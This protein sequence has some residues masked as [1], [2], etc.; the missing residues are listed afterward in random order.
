MPAAGSPTSTQVPLL[1]A[2]AETEIIIGTATVPA[3]PTQSFATLTPSTQKNTSTPAPTATATPTPAATATQPAGSCTD[4]L[5]FVED[6]TVPDN[7]E[8][9]PGEDFTKTWRLQNTGTCTW[10]SAYSLVFASGDQMNGTSPSP[11]VGSTAPGSTLDVSVNLKAPGTVG[12]Y[13]GNW[14]LKNPSGTNFGS[15]ANATQPFY[16]L[17]NVVEGV[18]DLNLGAPTWTDNMDTADNWFLLSTANT[19]FTEGDGKLVMTASSPSGGDEW[20]LSNKPSLTDYYLQATFIT[21]SACSGLDRYGLLARAPDPSQGYVLEFSCDGHYRLY[22]WDGKNYSAIQE[23]K[24]V[25]S[26]HT[27]PNQTN[28]MGFWMKGTTLRIYANGYKLAEFTDS[29]FNHGQFGLVI[30]SANTN[31][32][33]TSVDQISYW[34]LTSQ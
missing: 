12:T 27:G 9:L 23:W 20:G 8:L 16:V 24:S 1:T 17:I 2:A 34:D 26:I 30:G 14:M 11:L 10:T 33:T 31:N 5:K 21:G 4:L 19:K 22:I 32:F 6:V 3:T 28:I 29:K 15:G 18:S 13:Q 7:T 25:A